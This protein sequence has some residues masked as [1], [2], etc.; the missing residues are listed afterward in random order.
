MV[1]NLITQGDI[2]RDLAAQCPH[3]FSSSHPMPMQVGV[4]V[5]NADETAVWEITLWTETGQ[6]EEVLLHLDLII[7]S[8]S[9]DGMLQAVTKMHLRFA[10]GVHGAVQVSAPRCSYRK[11]FLDTTASFDEPHMCVNC[12]VAY[13]PAF[14]W[15]VFMHQIHRICAGWNAISDRMYCH[16]IRDRHRE[17]SSWIHRLPRDINSRQGAEAYRDIRWYGTSERRVCPSDVFLRICREHRPC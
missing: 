9:T 16:Q 4:Q 7:T 1:C 17:C 13:S 12:S 14:G 11:Q 5:P 6:E 15:H 8:N 10:L 2:L 3:I